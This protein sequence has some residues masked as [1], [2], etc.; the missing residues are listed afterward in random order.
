MR[1]G[2]GAGQRDGD[3]SGDRHAG[4]DGHATTGG[5]TAAGDIDGDQALRTLTLPDGVLVDVLA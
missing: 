3:G 5:T 4:G 1:D 2:T